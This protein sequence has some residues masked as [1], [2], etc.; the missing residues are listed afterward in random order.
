MSMTNREGVRTVN[1]HQLSSERALLGKA[2]DFFFLPALALVSKSLEARTLEF[3][4]LKTKQANRVREGG[5][6][7]WVRCK[8][9][10]THSHT[11][12]FLRRNDISG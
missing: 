12:T 5:V 2:N 11:H 4:T 1:E 8:W 3:S 7:G 10:D 6:G 9:Q